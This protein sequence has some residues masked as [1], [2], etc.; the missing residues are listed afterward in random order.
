MNDAQSVTDPVCGMTVDPATAISGE[1]DGQTWYF[2]CEHCRKKFLEPAQMV[3]LSLSRKEAAEAVYICPMHLEIEQVGPGS[4]PICGMDLEPK[5]VTSDSDDDSELRSMTRRFWIAVALSLPVFLVA[6]LPMLGVPLD[7]IISPSVSR[8]LQFLLSTPVVFWCGWPLLVRGWQSIRTGN[9]NMFT[10]ISLGVLAAWLYSTAALL[11][12]GWIPEAFREHGE[13]AV[14]FEA[15]AVIIALVLLG[16]VLELRARRKTGSAIRELMSL[17][18][19]TARL[20]RDGVETEIPL[21]QVQ[22]GDVL[23]VVPGDKIPVDGEVER[24]SSA[25]DESM[26]T[27]E[28]IPVTKQPGDDVTGGTVNQTG[29]FQMRATRVGNETVLSQIVNLVASA[30]RSR[31]P[32]QKVADQVA[33]WFV[34][35]VIVVAVI[36]FVVWAIWSPREPS[37]AYA[38]VNSV[39]VLII[40]CPC[41]LGLATPI[42]IMVGVGRGAREG[43]LIRDAEVLETLEKVDT[44]VVDKTG[45]LT[46]GKPRLTEIRVADESGHSP[47]LQRGAGGVLD[48]DY[49][50]QLAAAVETGSEHPLASA[51]VEET[52]KRHLEI[53]AVYEFDSITGGGVIGRVEEQW[54]LIGNRE[55][56]A[57]REIQNRDALTEVATNLQN[58]GQT[59]VFV[60][61]DGA[62]AGLLAV[63]DPIKESTPS[64]ID[65]L[66]RLGVDTVMLTGDNERTARHVAGQL[67]IDNVQAEVSPA[68]KQQHILKLQ[69]AGRRVA[70]AG[71]GIN[72]APALA[73]ADVGIAMGTGTDVAMESAGVTLVRG[74][75]NGIVKAIHLSH[76]TMRNIRQNLFFAFAYN[77]LGIPIAAGVLVPVFGFKALLNPMIAAAAMSFSSVSVISNALRLRKAELD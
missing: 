6:M 25:V 50:L 75:L 3:T 61:I 1:K 70:M 8:W 65:A 34:P 51:I 4:C 44:L 39:A 55:L 48:Q 52:R 28:P 11:I 20:I 33:G 12:P 62:L 31:A 19:P 41:A 23:K 59:V 21:E 63:S 72:D 47:L 54:V 15:A 36:T 64:A 76:A 73:A 10:L 14:Y 7:R 18:P 77:A 29:S 58:A 71:D 45:T 22:R 30:Q 68:E 74:D 38:L 24:G 26:I 56:F 69:Q 49:L 35:A 57:M 17:T 42:S 5:F 37:L 53:P 67:G 9:L 27:G 66:H 2:C 43:I 60:A 46:A 32:I 16:Q 13:V 40:A